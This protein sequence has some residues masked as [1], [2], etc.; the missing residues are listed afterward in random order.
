MKKIFVL[1]FLAFLSSCTPAKNTDTTD[2][3]TDVA[4]TLIVAQPGVE[5]T[6]P[7]DSVK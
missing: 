2:S 4:D 1:A 6:V 3:T 7:V 5:G